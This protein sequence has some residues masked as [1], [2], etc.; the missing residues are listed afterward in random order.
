MQER[1]FD[2]Y[3]PTRISEMPR[4]E[5]HIV[6]SEVAPTGIGEP[7]PRTVLRPVPDTA[8]DWAVRL[9]AIAA[10]VVGCWWAVH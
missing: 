2:S 10:L 5:V 9:L 3:Q 6:P 8:L 7:G 4:V 1:N